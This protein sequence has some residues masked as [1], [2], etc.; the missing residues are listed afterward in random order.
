MPKKVLITGITGMVGS[1]LADFLVKNTDW[2]I[3]G[4]CRWRSPLDNISHLVG[5]INR[6]ERVQ[7]LYGDLNCKLLPKY[8]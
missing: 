4:M 7:L 8:R 3:F 1:H 6:G 5:E 2:D